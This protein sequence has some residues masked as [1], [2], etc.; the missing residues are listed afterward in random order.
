[1]G[2]IDGNTHQNRSLSP[3]NRGFYNPKKMSSQV[4]GQTAL[5]QTDIIRERA[6][7]TKYKK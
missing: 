5:S 7:V 6:A 2:K 1:M 3:F 4:N